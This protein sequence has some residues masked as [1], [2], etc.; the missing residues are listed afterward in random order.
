MK[1]DN[2]EKSNGIIS[3]LF[4]TFG[5][6]ITAQL[7]TT[8]V[9][10]ILARI[11]DPYHYGIVSIVT[12]FITFC[13]IFVSGGFGSAVVQKK[14]STEDD[15]NTAFSLSLFLSIILYVILF[16]VS[17][18]IAKFYNMEELTLVTRIMG[19]RLIVASLNTIQHAYIQKQM[20]FKKFFYATLFGTILS[21]IVGIILAYYK[22]GV[23][24]LVAQYLTNTIVDTTVLLLLGGW[25]PKLKF[26]ANNAKKLFSFGWKVLVTEL[27]YTLEGDIRSLIIGKTFGPRDLAFYD[28]GKKYPVLLVNNINSSINKVMLP[29]YSKTQDNKVLLKSMLRKSIKVGIYILAPIL[30]G[31]GAVSNNFVSLIL[32]DK[33]MECIPYIQVF[34]IIY[35][36][37]PLETS[38]H[39][40]LLALG[41]SGLVMKIIICVN[42]IAVITVLIAVFLFHSVLFIAIG[43]LIST[44]VSICLFMYMSYKRIDYKP[45]EQL[46]DIFLPLF[47]SAI[48]G[49]CVY[50]IGRINISIIC[51]LIIQVLVGILI[52]FVFSY[53]MNIE[54]YIYIKD[55]FLNR[56]K[57]VLEEDNDNKENNI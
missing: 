49:I 42:I 6:R 3:G 31:F 50:L 37:R 15:F 20:K 24:A 10:I 27:I 14:D 51:E 33:W 11:L 23:W 18:F 46:H 41:E 16:I 4:W 28:Q 2:N 7:V 8:I 34:C 43:S 52:Y 35:L 30:I 56:K 53:F 22:F 17:P 44:I 39:Q 55:K 19:V 12:I 47:A 48:M 13:N 25:K 9:T 32:T 57:V 26:K 29:A 5:E 40:A 36:T 38:C 54:G 45:K 1:K 21:A